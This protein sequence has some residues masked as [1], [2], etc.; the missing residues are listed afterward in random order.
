MA[1]TVHRDLEHYIDQELRTL[2]AAAAKRIFKGALIGISPAGFARPLEAGDPF[3]GI[4]YEEMDNTA[5]ANG[6]RTVRVYTLGDFG[7]PL[8]GATV[9][10]IGRPV[11]A[12]DDETLTFDGA[13]NSLVG[14]VQDVPAAGQILLRIE[15]GAGRI[16]TVTH[17]VEDL[18]AGLDITARAVHA[19]GQAAWITA[20]RVVNQST[21]AAGINDAN[22]CVVQL[23]IAAAT[24]AGKTFDTA[25]PFPAVN[26]VAGMGAIAAPR[27]AAGNVLNVAVTNGTSANPG[28]FLIEVDYL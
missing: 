3:A 8:A 24:V 21:A 1:L 19:F 4:A 6:D 22:T 28:P 2:P 20:A 17:L 11:F 16:K 18:T 9:A 5:G 23:T 15:P 26:A 25:N 7:M 13:G 27:A 14:V 10:F 12:A